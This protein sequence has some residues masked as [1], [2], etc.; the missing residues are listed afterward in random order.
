MM[1]VPLVGLL[2]SK[3]RK[4]RK[5]A[6]SIIIRLRAMKLVWGLGLK[7]PKLVDYRDDEVI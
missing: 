1:I 7:V 2:G 5:V 6:W 3:K 4:S